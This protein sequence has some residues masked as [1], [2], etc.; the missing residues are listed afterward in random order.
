MRGRCRSRRAPR[1]EAAAGTGCPALR[2]AEASSGWRWLRRPRRSQFG[3]A[4]LRQSRP[5]A[6]DGLWTKPHTA[7]PRGPSCRI[8]RRPGGT[9]SMPIFPI[10]LG[11][12]PRRTTTAI[13]YLPG[14][15]R[16]AVDA[17][18]EADAV[19]PLLAWHPLAS[20][21]ARSS[22]SGRS[23]RARPPPAVPGGSRWSCRGAGRV[24]R[25]ASARRARCGARG[26]AQATR[27]RSPARPAPE[28]APLP[29]A[30]AA[31]GRRRRRRR[32]RHRRWRC[33]GRQRRRRRKRRRWRKRGQWRWRRQRRRGRQRGRGR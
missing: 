7:F 3:R 20:N 6:G 29:L 14:A 5:R 8:T 27:R 21:D 17:A 25:S 33:A 30:V 16:A 26:P 15:Q 12:P 11:E 9:T 22:G 4:P 1:D 10:R 23:P 28:A 2:C 31:A 32:E 19:H 24:R 13:A 18:G